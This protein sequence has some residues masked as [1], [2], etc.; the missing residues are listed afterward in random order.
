VL[1]VWLPAPLPTPRALPDHG[2]LWPLAVGVEKDLG[3]IDVWP[4]GIVCCSLCGLTHPPS[5]KAKFH[6]IDCLFHSVAES[7]CLMFECLD[8]RF[9]TTSDMNDVRVW[10]HVSLF[11]PFIPQV[12]SMAFSKATGIDPS[13]VGWWYYSPNSLFMTVRI[14]RPLRATTPPPL[15][16]QPHINLPT[17][18]PSGGARMQAFQLQSLSRWSFVSVSILFRFIPQVASMAFSKATGI[19]PVADTMETMASLS[20]SWDQFQTEQQVFM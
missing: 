9:I 4:C 18:T 12:A 2:A 11:F 3:G 15:R 6:C 7:R 10:Q 1:G 13:F 8:N 5:I 19:D 17:T 14:I 16:Y 20:N